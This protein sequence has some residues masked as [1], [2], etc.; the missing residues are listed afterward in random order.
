MGIV[1]AGALPLY[2]EIDKDL[3][4]LLEDVVLNRRKDATERLLAFAETISQDRYQN[5]CVKMH[6]R[7][8]DVNERIKYS[9]INGIDDYIEC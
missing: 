7:E 5:N 4:K 8:L 1:N 3:L 9:L 6:W 2:D